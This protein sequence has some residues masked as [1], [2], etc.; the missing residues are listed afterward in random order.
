MATVITTVQGL[1]D[2]NTALS[3]DYELGADIDLNGEVSWSPLGTSRALVDTG[4]TDGTTSNKLV[5]STQNFQTTIAVGDT[6][7][8]R[9]DSTTATVSGI[10]SDTQL[11]LSSN[12]MA[13]GE[14]YDIY[15]PRDGFTGKFDGKGF[16]IS[17]LALTDG[18]GEAVALFGKITGG[19]I[20]NL[21]LVDFTHVAT[22]T[23][24]ANETLTWCSALLGLMGG[25]G[26]ILSNITIT[27]YDFDYTSNHE[28]HTL[29]G[30]GALAGMVQGCTISNC[31]TA[32]TIDVTGTASS[33]ATGVFRGIGGAIGEVQGVTTITDSSSSVAITITGNDKD[34]TSVFS[35]GFIGWARGDE[36]SGVTTINNL[37]LT[38][39]SASGALVYDVCRPEC[40]GFS[41]ILNLD[42][43]VGVITRCSASG[44][45]TVT[46]GNGILIGGFCPFAVKESAATSF[47]MI[48]CSYT[49]NISITADDP[50]ELIGGFIG[51]SISMSQILRCFVT[52][53]ITIVTPQGATNDAAV[54]GGLIGNLDMINGA[55]V[56]DCYYTGDI[57][58]TAGDCF[59]LGGLIGELTGVFS[60][61][62]TITGCYSTGGITINALSV[63]FIGGLIGS[64]DNWYTTSEVSKCYYNGTMTMTVDTRDA[65][66]IGGL[67]GH[68]ELRG[69]SQLKDCYTKGSMSITGVS[70]TDMTNIGGTFGNLLLFGSDDPKVSN[71]YNSMT[72][73]CT[74]NDASGFSEIG[75]F[76]GLYASNGGT[77]ATTEGMFNCYSVG[78]VTIQDHLANNVTGG[79]VG[80]F[81][82]KMS[83]GAVRNLSWWTGAWNQAMGNPSGTSFA[84]SNRGTDEADADNFKTDTSH[85]VYAQ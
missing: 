71:C 50:D 66:D 9:T 39:C 78:L 37:I 8:N 17:N 57:N 25:T 29:R 75:G 13:S 4:T 40:G 6:V 43:G 28:T 62:T 30:V 48:D 60:G 79:V 15:N 80:G 36:F 32:G 77:P 35:G 47:T 81:G 18:K 64:L 49:G 56:T 5:D 20:K 54:I 27:G 7:I 63:T 65:L 73:T 12:I 21:T 45:F 74:G 67:I 52:G 69:D 58:V 16:T 38:D 68:C 55:D 14:D 76:V 41:G 70:G 44:N 3:A 72:V 51:S 61:I 23:N 34:L 84:G 1:K 26:N 10:D 83:S 53:N 42:L 59:S 31:T 46:N 82:G 22:V 2:I 19:T 24:V 85:T 11:S 33:S